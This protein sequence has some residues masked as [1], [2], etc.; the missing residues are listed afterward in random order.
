LLRAAQVL[1]AIALHIAGLEPYPRYHQLLE[2]DTTLLASMI[3]LLV[4]FIA[5]TD[6]PYRGVHA[7]RPRAYEIALGNLTMA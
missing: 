7:I 6:H 2:T 3:A 4:F 1:W 5:T